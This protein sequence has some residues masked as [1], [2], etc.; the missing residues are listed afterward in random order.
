MKQVASGQVVFP[1]ADGRLIYSAGG[2]G[3][4]LDRWFRNSGVS[5][6]IYTNLCPARPTDWLNRIKEENNGIIMLR[7]QKTF[8][9]ELLIIFRHLPRPHL[10]LRCKIQI[11]LNKIYFQTGKSQWM[12][13]L[14]LATLLIIFYPDMYCNSGLHEKIDKWVRR[15]APVLRVRGLNPTTTW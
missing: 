12:A 11:L 1:V 4:Y 3:L 8:F 9:L 2:R 7:Q 6:A 15:R 5:I 13:F 14:R 10:V